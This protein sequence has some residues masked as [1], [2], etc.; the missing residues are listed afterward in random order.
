ML[1]IWTSQNHFP[2]FNFKRVFEN[3]KWGLRLGNL[4]PCNLNFQIIMGLEENPN[5]KEIFFDYC[6]EKRSLW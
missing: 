2:I 5:E 4:E 1:P 3:L 6:G